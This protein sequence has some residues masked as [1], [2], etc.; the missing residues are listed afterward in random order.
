MRLRF[1]VKTEIRLLN[2]AAMWLLE[3]NCLNQKQLNVFE[4]GTKNI[5]S[6]DRIAPGCLQ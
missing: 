3:K 2:K 6:S 4:F 1:Y 5:Y